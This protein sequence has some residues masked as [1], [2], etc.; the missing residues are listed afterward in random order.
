MSFKSKAEKTQFDGLSCGMVVKTFLHNVDVFT[1]QKNN[2]VVGNFVR[3][4]KNELANFDGSAN[5]VVVGVVKRKLTGSVD[6]IDY[7][8]GENVEVISFGYVVVN[9]TSN[10]KIKRFDKVFINNVKGADI[11]TATN[12]ATNN[13]AIDADFFKEVSAKTWVV[14]LKSIL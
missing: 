6:D 7:K 12:V 10:I 2:S 3:F 5:P 11:G 13:V 14:R 1:K 4:D 9:I 8:Q